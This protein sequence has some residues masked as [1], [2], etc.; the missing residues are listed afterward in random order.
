MSRTA[1]RL[2][3]ACREGKKNTPTVQLAPGARLG[4]QLLVSL[5]SAAFVPV[6]LIPLIESGPAPLLRTVMVCA[7]LGMPTLCGAKLRLEGEI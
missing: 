1:A 6:T 7:A 5:K 2:A 3:A 4:G